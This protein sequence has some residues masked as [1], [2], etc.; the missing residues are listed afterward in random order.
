MRQPA[1]IHS[2]RSQATPNRRAAELGRLV[3]RLWLD[4][5]TLLLFS[6]QSAEGGP[7]RYHAS[8]LD[9]EGKRVVI[10]RET[11]EDVVRAALGCED[12]KVCRGCG[13]A[14]TLRCFSKNRNAS[15][16]HLSRCKKCETERVKA[17][18]RR[19]AQ[20]AKAPVIH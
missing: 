10:T 3:E 11:P 20:P 14:K 8:A 15:D 18:Q 1:A 7:V 4:F 2:E 12:A 16:K 19:Q 13:Q 6:T 17:Y 9:G 5:D